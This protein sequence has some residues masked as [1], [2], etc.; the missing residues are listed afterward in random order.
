MNFADPTYKQ[1]TQEKSIFQKYH[2]LHV[3]KLGQNY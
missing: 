3:H 1:S 2:K